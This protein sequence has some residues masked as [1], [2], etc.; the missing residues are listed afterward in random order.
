MPIGR[1]LDIVAETLAG[2]LWG[3][4]VVL[5][6]LTIF[7]GFLGQFVGAV[8]VLDPSTGAL[9]PISIIAGGALVGAYWRYRTVQQNTGLAA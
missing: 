4:L 8:R 3:L 1:R 7:T 5:V 2:G 6:G 9:L